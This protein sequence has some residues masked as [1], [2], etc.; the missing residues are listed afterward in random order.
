MTYGVFV[1][2]ARTETTK[3]AFPDTTFESV[4]EAHNFA[5]YLNLRI[6][7]KVYLLYFAKELNPAAVALGSTKS[8]R[9]AR[10]SAENGKK[11]GRPRKTE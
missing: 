1:R 10:S 4:K 6:K 11:G 9:K 8:E 5:E 2:N 7:G 3:R